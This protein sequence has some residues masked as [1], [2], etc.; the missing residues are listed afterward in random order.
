[1]L[2]R[3]SATELAEWVE[4]EELEGPIGDRRA[5]Y[6]AG[7]IALHAI[8]PY[9]KDPEVPARLRDYLI[10]YEHSA[11]DRTELDV[12]DPTLLFGTFGV[13]DLS[14]YGMADQTAEEV[15]VPEGFFS[16]SIAEGGDNGEL[17]N[18][19]SH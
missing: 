2:R 7:W 9:R 12:D 15:E 10:K 5:D 1:L 13:A 16:T 8:A 17:F 18:V 6:N 14:N 11:E 4:F 3:I 19:N